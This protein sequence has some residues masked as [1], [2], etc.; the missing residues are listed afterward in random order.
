LNLDGGSTSKESGAFHPNSR[1]SA[2]RREIKSDVSKKNEGFKLRM[3]CPGHR[4]APTTKTTE[5]SCKTSNDDPSPLPYHRSS[6]VNWFL[7]AV[8]KVDPTAVDS[9]G[10]G[11]V[12]AMETMYNRSGMGKGVFGCRYEHA[13]IVRCRWCWLVGWFERNNKESSGLQRQKYEKSDKND[14]WGF[15]YLRIFNINQ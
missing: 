5:S 6:L 11:Y 15:F 7:H 1:D 4:G 14:I 2:A 10:I 9:L 8:T 13:Q 3:E 12:P